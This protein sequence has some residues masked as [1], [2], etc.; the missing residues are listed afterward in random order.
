MPQPQPLTHHLAAQIEIAVA[1]A[2]F[3][4]DLLVELERQGLG[5]VEELD[6]LRDELDLAGGEVRVHGAGG[7]LAHRAGTAHHVLVAQPLGF[8]EHLGRVRVEDDLQQPLAVAQVDE[9][10]PAV[11]APAVHPAGDRD[12]AAELLLVDLSAVMRAHEA[13]DVTDAPTAPQPK[14]RPAFPAPP[15]P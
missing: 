1:Q 11:V 8:R 10:H 15:P 6:A 4:A 3:L 9:D 12:L 14:P 7:P 5:A 2:H 13:R